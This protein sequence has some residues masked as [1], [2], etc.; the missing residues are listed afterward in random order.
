MD[1]LFKVMVEYGLDKDYGGDA[2]EYETMIGPDGKVLYDVRNFTYCPEDAI[3]ARGLVSSDKIIRYIE[4]GMKLAAEGYTSVE[5]D[6][7]LAED[8]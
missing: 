2:H 8:E 3:I 4:L 1:K 7:K 5:A 6:Y